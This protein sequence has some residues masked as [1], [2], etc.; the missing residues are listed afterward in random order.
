MSQ[1]LALKIPVL[2]DEVWARLSPLIESELGIRM[3]VEKKTLLQN[4]LL[5]RVKHHGFERFEDYCDY[6]FSDEGKA[7]E[8]TAFFNEVTTNKT[9]FFREYRH[10]EV[11]SDRILPEN[12]ARPVAQRAPLRIWSAACSTGEELYSIACIIEEYMRTEGVILSYE[13]IGSD[14]STR[15]LWHAQNAIYDESQINMISPDIIRRYFHAGLDGKENLRRVIPEIRSR[16]RLRKINLMNLAYPFT[17]PFDVIF[18]RNVLI[19]FSRTDIVQ[20]VDRCAKH[21]RPGGYFIV[22]HADSIYGAS[23]KFRRIEPSIFQIPE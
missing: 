7:N 18:C 9:F 3:P 22:G 6:L 2:T 16:V 12:L 14:I 17:Q 10:F 23:T 20:I 4:R 19:Y 21:L 5:R 8:R 1:S 13:I 15:V 11:L